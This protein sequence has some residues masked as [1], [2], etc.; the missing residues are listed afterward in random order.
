MTAPQDADPPALDLAKL[1]ADLSARVVEAA[2]LPALIA[3]EAVPGY[4]GI[5]RPVMFRLISEGKFPKS[6]VINGGGKKYRRT[7]LDKWVAALKPAR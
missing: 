1:F 3:Q 2:R 6:V 4:V 5:S 7:D